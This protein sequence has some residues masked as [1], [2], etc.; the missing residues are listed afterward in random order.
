MASG[1]YRRGTSYEK[2]AGAMQSMK[3]SP[4][5]S[6]LRKRKAV[7]CDDY[8][9]ET[10][11]DAAAT[12]NIHDDIVDG[13]KAKRLH[14]KKDL[15]EERRLKR[16]RTGPPRTYLERLDRVRTQR[17]FLIDRQKRVG[18]D[19]VTEEEVFDLA[20][21]TGNVY[22]ITIRKVP[23][24]TCPDNGKGNQCKHIIYVCL[25]LPKS[26]HRHH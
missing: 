19:G 2:Q 25:S 13:S 17:M 10:E 9:E 20:G 1:S 7:V 23:R 24:C 6:Q 26:S 18:N 15:G 3:S 12:Q 8:N 21:S 14:K 11:V 22:Q 5:T 4:T 16:F